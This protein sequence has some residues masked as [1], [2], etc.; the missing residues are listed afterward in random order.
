MT[1]VS[2]PPSAFQA[3]PKEEREAHTSASESGTPRRSPAHAADTSRR[4]HSHEGIVGCA[5]TLKQETEVG[6]TNKN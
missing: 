5:E 6:K 4:T 2:V 3:G 1:T